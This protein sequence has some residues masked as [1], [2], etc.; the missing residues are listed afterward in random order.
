[1]TMPI[2]KA[3]SSIGARSPPESNDL[4]N[5]YLVTA[6]PLVYIRPAAVDLTIG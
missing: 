3:Q 4:I 5:D 1:M 2:A 6:F